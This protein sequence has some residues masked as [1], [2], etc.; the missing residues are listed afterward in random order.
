MELILIIYFINSIYLKLFYFQHVIRMLKLS[1]SHF[2]FSL[3]FFFLHMLSLQTL[4][5]ILHFQDI[6]IWTSHISTAQEPPELLAT[7]LDSTTLELDLHVWLY[8]GI[9]IVWFGLSLGFAFLCKLSSSF[10]KREIPSFVWA[11]WPTNQFNLYC[12]YSSKSQ[13]KRYSDSFDQSCWYHL[14]IHE[15]IPEARGMEPT[16]T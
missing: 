4:V 15:P 16:P 9:Q 10:L 2:S 13:R 8:P 7:I 11:R 14:F 12:T 6:S 3:F 1:M 5:C